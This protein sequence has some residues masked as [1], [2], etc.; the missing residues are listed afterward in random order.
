M[1]VCACVRAWVCVRA[2]LVCWRRQGGRGYPL[3]VDDL[4]YAH[5]GKKAAA[6]IAECDVQNRGL[7]LV[8]IALMALDAWGLLKQRVPE[9]L[10]EAGSRKSDFCLQKKK[11]DSGAGYLPLARRTCAP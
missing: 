3:A 10:F 6:F 1:C 8:L 7:L 9:S 4:A 11:R 5:G 2:C